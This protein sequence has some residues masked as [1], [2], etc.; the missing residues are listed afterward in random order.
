MSKSHVL[1]LPSIDEGFGMVLAEAMAC[2]CPVIA[3]TNTGAPNLISNGRDGF[4]VPIRDPVAITQKLEMMAQCPEMR[5]TMSD[6]ALARTQQ[7]GGWDSYGDT[8]CDLFERLVDAK[9]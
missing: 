3:T 5:A 1:V 8:V 7:L 9:Q 6:R 2:G 4:I